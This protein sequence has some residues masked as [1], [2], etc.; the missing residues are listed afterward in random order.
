M[1]TFVTA[2]LKKYGKNQTWAVENVSL[3]TLRQLFD[4]FIDGHLELSNPAISSNPLYVDLKSLKESNTV[5]YNLP[6]DTWLA[7]LNDTPLPFLSQE[8]VYITKSAYYADAWQA[9][10]DIQRCVAN[11]P[12]IITG[13][14][15]T[16]V[17]L[18]KEGVDYSLLKT[19]VLT[20]VNGLFHLNYGIDDY[21][22]IKDAGK[23]LLCNKTDENKIGLLSFAHVC[24][25]EQIP[26]TVNMLTPIALNI[27]YKQAVVIKTGRDLT[28][29]SIMIS[30]GGY[31]H[32]A[33]KIIDVISAA[34]GAIR[35]NM[36][37]LSFARRVFEMRHYMDI[38]DLQLTQSIHK[39]NALVID[40][41]NTNT[42][43][44]RLLTLSQ[45]FLIIVDT[46]VLTRELIAVKNPEI[47][48][49]YEYGKEPLYPLITP[50]GRINDY[51]LSKQGEH[52]VLSV[53]DNFYRRYSYESTDWE[54][55]NV[56]SEQS[57]P[58][59]LIYANGN[60]LKLS[61]HWRT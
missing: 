37:Y 21:L 22:L 6:L 15:L 46:P 48:R 45:S 50:T 53:T 2:I 31:L 1:Y 11:N 42:F 41:L 17:R 49:F 16:D 20:S 44:Q 40:D 60:L 35:L 10:Y 14:N 7:S 23:S 29:K 8:P 26:I 25:I 24:A 36:E 28:N 54:Q 3:L 32:C 55:G 47:P 38:S 52:Y 27:P 9:R 13:N 34:E 58:D 12:N 57:V 33:D 19:R 39:P 51:W 18:S 30:I 56:V 61:A 43:I 4:T 59:E 5:F